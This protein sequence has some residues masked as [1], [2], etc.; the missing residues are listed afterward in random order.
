MHIF[1]EEKK[2]MK[3]MCLALE[4]GLLALATL[5]LAQQSSK[6]TGWAGWEPFIGFW[7]GAGDSTQGTSSFSFLPDLRDKILV[8]KNHADYPATK[9]RPAI[10]HDDLMIVSGEN[11]ASR[12]AVY[13]DNEGHVIE[14]AVSVAPDGRSLVFLSLAAAHAPRYR[15][16]YFRQG[17]DRLRI[18]FEIAP[19]GKPEA[20]ALYLEGVCRRKA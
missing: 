7:V 4:I 3:R 18:T 16:A 9:D 15:L 17:P 11:D 1:A 19:P 10:V 20:F 6:S 2:L 14:Y 8:R 5:A 12:R 13:F